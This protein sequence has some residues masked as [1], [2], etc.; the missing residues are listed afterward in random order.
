MWH[1]IEERL[2]QKNSGARIFWFLRIFYLEI[3]SIS[4]KLKNF[5]KRFW[6]N[7]EKNSFREP[8]YRSLSL[9]TGNE[10]FRHDDVTMT[11]FLVTS[12]H[13]WFDLS[14]FFCLDFEKSQ[15]KKFFENWEIRNFS[16]VWFLR[17][18]DVHKNGRSGFCL[19]RYV[20]QFILWPYFREWCARWYNSKAPPP[21]TNLRGAIV[22]H[23]GLATLR[24]LD[25]FQHL[26]YIRGVTF[27]TACTTANDNLF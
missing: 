26:I 11:S 22:D 27:F 8:V 2:P 1:C 9:L 13:Y 24:K 12:S 19:E 4:G 14:S 25:S 18:V 10:W 20:V 23:G 16:S 6:Q 17:S 21:P 15:K 3:F 7:D 5:D